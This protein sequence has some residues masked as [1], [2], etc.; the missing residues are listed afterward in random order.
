MVPGLPAAA[1]DDALRLVS[2]RIVQRR[3]VKEQKVGKSGRCLVDGAAAIRA[4]GAL[5]VIAAIGP[6]IE[7][8]RLS[9][10][11]DGGSGEGELR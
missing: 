6:D 1:P 4:E 7:E 3:S 10:D 9:I 2:A 5:N 11:L 8:R